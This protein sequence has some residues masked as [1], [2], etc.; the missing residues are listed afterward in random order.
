MHF[1]ATFDEDIYSAYCWKD[2]ANLGVNGWAIYSGDEWTDTTL[3]GHRETVRAR[4]LSTSK[5]QLVQQHA[6]QINTWREVPCV[7]R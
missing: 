6:C 7:T 3:I 4:R 1:Y 5:L 2:V